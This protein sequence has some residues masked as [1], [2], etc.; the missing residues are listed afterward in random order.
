MGLTLEQK[1]DCLTDNEYNA[2][3]ELVDLLLYNRKEKRVGY[4]DTEEK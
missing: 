4:G 3:E 2:I 1:I